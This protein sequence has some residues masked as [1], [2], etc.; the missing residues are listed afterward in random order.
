MKS[1]AIDTTA[2]Q[3]LGLCL[4]NIYV[5]NVHTAERSQ[6]RLSEAPLGIYLPVIRLHSFYLSLHSDIYNKD[7]PMERL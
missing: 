4:Q 6:H 7:Q 1:S 2:H 5:A 3:I